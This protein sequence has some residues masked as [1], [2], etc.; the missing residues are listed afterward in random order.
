MLYI[1]FTTLLPRHHMHTDTL[2]RLSYLF[3]HQS[4]SLVQKPIIKIFLLIT[5]VWR[6]WLI[7]LVNLEY[8][9]SGHASLPLCVAMSQ[10]CG[11]PECSF[12]ILEGR[13]LIG[14]YMALFNV[15]TYRFS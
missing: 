4:Q 3:P 11:E 6:P 5:Y 2:P 7:V 12:H 15:L 10:H 9:F 14:Y 13:L 1:V 8:S